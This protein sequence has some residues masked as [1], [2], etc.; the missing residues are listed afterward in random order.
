MMKKQTP[1]ALAEFAKSA[2]AAEPG[3]EEKSLSATAK[4][5][6][7]PRDIQADQ[8]AATKVLQEGATGKKKGALAAVKKLPD[9]VVESR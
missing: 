9:R 8:K 1:E 2:R 5:K 4:T 7:K 3:K 6:P